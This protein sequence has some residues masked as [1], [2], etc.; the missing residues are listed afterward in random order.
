MEKTFNV[1]SS[2]A[3]Q[4]GG[5]VTKIQRTETV[6]TVFGNKVA[7]ET[8]YVSG[9][10]QMPVNTPIQ[11]DMTKWRVESYPFDIVDQS[12]GVVNRISLKWLHVRI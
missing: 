5:F 10:N 3:N 8:Y 1:V 12:T 9:S 2:N 7:K 11:L 4:K 6:Q